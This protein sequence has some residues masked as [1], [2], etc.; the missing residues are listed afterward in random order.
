[1]KV[2]SGEYLCE[3]YVNAIP[4]AFKIGIFTVKQLSWKV[5]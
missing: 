2:K 1:M 3:F 4:M 5:T